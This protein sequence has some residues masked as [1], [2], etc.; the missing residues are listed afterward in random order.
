LGP[1][2]LLTLSVKK[3]KRAVPEAGSDENSQLK[4][5]LFVF[6]F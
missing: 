5:G 6:N 3:D 4:G 2:H 1:K